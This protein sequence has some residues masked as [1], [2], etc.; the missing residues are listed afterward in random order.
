MRQTLAPEPAAAA[1]IRPHDEVWAARC[2]S[3]GSGH[4]AVVNRNRN[5][6][7]LWRTASPEAPRACQKPAQGSALI[8]SSSNQT[9]SAE[10]NGGPPTAL[11][12]GPPTPSAT[13]M[14]CPR[15]CKAAR[16][17]PV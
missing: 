15:S 11:S 8:A 14:Q 12:G 16:S 6:G 13:A 17:N 9:P 1:A 3:P 10:R 4:V 2:N 7:Q 5:D